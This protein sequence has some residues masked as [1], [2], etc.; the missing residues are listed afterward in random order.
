[1]WW[2]AQ[3]LA[4]LP[5]LLLGLAV[6]RR[7]LS[8]AWAAAAAARTLGSPPAGP[9]AS[10]P[11]AARQPGG[12]GAARSGAGLPASGSGTMRYI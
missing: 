10:V 9:V 1:M 12:P 11:A 8:A 4:E 5:L 2:A 6:G 7:Q 3:W